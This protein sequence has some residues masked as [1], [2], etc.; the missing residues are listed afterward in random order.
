L[1]GL[2]VVMPEETSTYEN[3]L[4][5]QRDLASYKRRVLALVAA[6]HA[7]LVFKDT[8]GVLDLSQVQLALSP[9][10]C[11][12]HLPLPFPNYHPI[13]AIVTCL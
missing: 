6:R 5:V 4:Q 8:P 3:A 11:H 7:I 12:P 2:Q 1:R 13:L 9:N 10:P